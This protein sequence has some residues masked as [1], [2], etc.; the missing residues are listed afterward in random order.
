LPPLGP[1]HADRTARTHLSSQSDDVEDDRRFAMST[2]TLERPSMSDDRTPARR[3]KGS[4]AVSIAAVWAIAAYAAIALVLVPEGSPSV[5]ARGIALSVILTVAGTVAWMVRRGGVA[6]GWIMTLAAMSM[7]AVAGGIVVPRL[8]AGFTVREVIGA[9]ALAGGVVLLV[10]GWEA[11][12][13]RFRRRSVRFALAAVATLVVAQFLL[14]PVGAALVATNRVRPTSSGATPADEGF[15]FEDVRIAAEDGTQLAAWW[16]PSRNGAAVIVLP[17]AGS[18]RDDALP[19]AAFVA[20]H[21][22]GALILD[23]RGHGDSGGRSME[24]GWGGERDVRAAVSWVLD[25]DVARV[26]LYGLSMGGEVALTAAA[27]DPRIDAVVAEGASARTW[28]DAGNEPDP[29]PVDL[30]N[31]WV[32]F[33]VA[34]LLTPEQPPPALLDLAPAIDAPTLLIAGSPSNERSLG[35][36]YADAAPGTITLWTIPDAPHVGGLA[37]EPSRYPERVLGHLDAALIPA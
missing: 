6:A 2:V 33:G 34:D 10:R 23:A 35:A 8:M 3:S 9:T 17:G 29:H 32:M 26:G 16:I 14:L 18:T 5:F 21:G 37:T 19:Q 7:L 4:V 31:T 22:Y 27:I 28:S 1:S 13:R 30:A 11:V 15:A 25:R 24:F 20:E 36:L 12:L